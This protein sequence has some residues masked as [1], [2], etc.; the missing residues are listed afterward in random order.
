MLT[1]GIIIVV[2]ADLYI[3]LKK[4][5]EAKERYDQYFS[6]TYWI[7]KQVEDYERRFRG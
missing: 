7:D 3:S 1:C 4:A 6:K 5:D 2:I